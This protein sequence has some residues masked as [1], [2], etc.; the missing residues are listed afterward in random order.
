VLER[1]VLPGARVGPGSNLATLV[2]TEAYWVRVSLP[3]KDLQHLDVPGYNGSQGSAATLVDSSGWSRGAARRGRTIRLLG[4]LEPQGRLARVLVQVNDPLAERVDGPPLLLGSY[5]RVQLQGRPLENT[6]RVPRELLR[7][8]SHLW[9]KT[10]AGELAVRRV[11]PVWGDADAVYL[12]DPLQPGEQVVT[13]NLETPVPG[14]A[15][16]TEARGAG[17]GEPPEGVAGESRDEPPT[18]T[19]G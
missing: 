15:L 6:V 13:T 14:M 11:Q 4:D 8:G 9:L 1:D 18:R 12:R 17:P 19:G 16:R 2:A 3:V 7:D 5:L 10:A